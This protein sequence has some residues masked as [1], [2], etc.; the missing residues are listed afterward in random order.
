M[1]ELSLIHTY[2]HMFFAEKAFPGN[3]SW[4]KK[5]IERQVSP[6]PIYDIV[7]VSGYCGRFRRESDFSEKEGKKS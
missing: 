5:F 3:D 6:T 1:V 2:R 4:K 7:I